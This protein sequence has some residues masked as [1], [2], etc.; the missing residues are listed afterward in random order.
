MK[1]LIETDIMMDIRNVFFLLCFSLFF[2]PYGGR[3][4]YARRRDRC[5][6]GP[7]DKAFMV[8]EGTT[9]SSLAFSPPGDFLAAGTVSGSVLIFS[10]KKTNPPV[11]LA[12]GGSVRTVLFLK[13]D[14]LVKGDSQ[15][16]ERSK[17]FTIAV[18]G[19]FGIKILRFDPSGKIKVVRELQKKGGV[20]VL[21]MDSGGKYIASGGRDRKVTLWKVKNWKKESVM[22]G[23]T[24]WVSALVFSGDGKKIC[25]AGWDNTV[26]AY[27]VAEG[28]L[29]WTNYD[30]RFAVNDLMI[31][32]DGK[33]VFSVSDDGRMRRI[34]LSDG[35]SLKKLGVGPAVGVVSMG[36]GK[37]IVLATWRGRVRFYSYS[38]LRHVRSFR[39]SSSTLRTLAGLPSGILA[40]G[41]E[42]GAIKVW[43]FSAGC[44]GK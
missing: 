20:M 16:E 7:P 12:L 33:T 38:K 6:I 3:S 28:K 5:K 15:D 26:R 14:S 30:H 39:A 13:N 25:S 22:V 18:G 23:H 27:G 19:D 44:L 41:G 9:V 31:G 32:R 8:P 29:L 34:R 1:P 4:S 10:V 42:H 35:K 24:S 2:F 11:K 36:K 37:T 43:T 40:I 21:A 17:H